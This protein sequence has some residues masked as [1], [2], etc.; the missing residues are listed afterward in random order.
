[1][2][3]NVVTHFIFVNLL[4]II[5]EKSC[6]CMELHPINGDIGSK[7]T[8]VKGTGNGTNGK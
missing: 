1:M 8:M 7:E 4:G 5:V 3:F 2:D 6:N